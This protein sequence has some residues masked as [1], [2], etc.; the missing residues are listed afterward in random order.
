MNQAGL[1]IEQGPP[2]SVP[3]RF[4]LVAPVFLLLAAAALLWR[5][6][7]V[8][9]ARLSPAA[10][11]IAHLFALGFMAMIMIG[12][13]MQMLPV[14][15]GSPVPKPRA[16]AAVTHAGVGLGT[17]ALAAGFLFGERWLLKAGVLALAAGFLVFVAA[18][19]VCLGRAPSQ[20]HTVRAMWMAVLSLLVAVVFGVMLAMLFGWGIAPPNSSVHS[21]HP[22]W[23]LLGWTGLLVVGVGFELVPMLQMTPHYPKPMTRYLSVAILALLVLWSAVLWI[24]DGRWGAFAVAC[25]VAMAVAY[26]LFAVMTMVL[27]QRRRRR[28][29]DVTLDFWRVGMGSLIGASLAWGVRVAWPGP[30]PESMDIL[31]GVL[32]MFGFAGSVISG[33]LYKIMPFLAWFHLQSMCGPGTL[34][35]NMKK[36]L[37]DARQRLQFRSQVLAL[38]LFCAAALWPGPFVYPAALALA[39]TAVLLEMNMLIVVRAYRDNLKQMRA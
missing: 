9:E 3:F 33:M 18:L 15:Q 4:F 31:I 6:P 17:L 26:M 36:I 28:L 16:T 23:S 7:M 2:I 27:Q 14:L 24:D 8:F 21:L 20:N 30:W 32:A 25:A 34:A 22:G 19:L 38:V 35:P 10:I 5:G 13:M 39:A 1:Q 29:P 12:A 37:P 11:A